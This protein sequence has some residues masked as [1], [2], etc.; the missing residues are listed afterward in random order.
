MIQ[1]EL[2]LEIAKRKGLKNKEHIEKD[3][4]QDLFLFNLYKKS[5]I[6]VFK[7]G[8]CLYKLYKMPRFSE[9]LDFSLLKVSKDIPEIVEDV[10]K[11]MQAEVKEVKRMKKSMLFKLGFK[12]II[13]EYNTLRIDVSLVNIVFGFETKNYVSNFIDINPFTLKVL[14]LEEMIAEKVHALFAREKARDLYDL[15][16]LL[17]LSRPDTKLIEKKLRLFKMKFSVQKL[18][19]KVEALESV[20]K[21]ELKPFLLEELPSYEM[22]KTFVFNS[23][24]IS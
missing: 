24:S 14:K 5:N 4:F 7:G 23:F 6:F 15:F 13:T 11:S 18:K 22:V 9:D 21:E 1:K 12:G 19:R 17:R 20:W 10:A 3:Y 16:F 8:T 2:L